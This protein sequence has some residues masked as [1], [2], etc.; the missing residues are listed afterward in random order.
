VTP[1]V[2][3]VVTLEAGGGRIAD[4]LAAAFAAGPNFS[5]ILPDEGGRLEPLRWFFG[6]FVLRLGLSHGEVYAP[7]DG[8]G[9]AIWMR[10]GRRAGFVAAARS[11]ALAL[12]RRFGPGGFRRAMRLMQATDAARARWASRKHW[13][14]VALGVD[15]EVQGRGVGSGLVEP[16]LRR[17]DAEG[18]S[19]YLETFEQRTLPFYERMGFRVTGEERLSGGAPP[20]WGME[21]APS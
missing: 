5:W 17:S 18:V 7:A 3:R 9:A 6:G 1:E 20:F 8:R 21:R 2:R 11:G 19:C 10:P 13:Y 15:P 16:V 14:L 12:P 4:A